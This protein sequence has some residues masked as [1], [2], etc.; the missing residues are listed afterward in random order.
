MPSIKTN[1]ARLAKEVR[2]KRVRTYARSRIA[3]ARHQIENDPTSEKTR[4]A[5]DIALKALDQAA[6]KGIIHK[7]NA[8]R[9]KSRLMAQL[10][11][12]IAATA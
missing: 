6:A 4:N 1:R 9:R 12:A 2:N 8:A 7:N 5:A 3:L 11:E 10:N